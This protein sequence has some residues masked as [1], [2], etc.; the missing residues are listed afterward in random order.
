MMLSD[1]K[2]RRTMLNTLENNAEVKTINRSI[3]I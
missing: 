3:G 2:G 1:L